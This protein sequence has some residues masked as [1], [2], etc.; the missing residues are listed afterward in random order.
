MG[1][2]DRWAWRKQIRPLDEK[3]GRLPGDSGLCAQAGQVNAFAV[4]DRPGCDQKGFTTARTTITAAATPGTSL[5][6][7]SALPVSL[8]SPLAS[9]SA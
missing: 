2:G 3:R 6:S 8:R 9:A 7:R 4:G 5:T 1:P